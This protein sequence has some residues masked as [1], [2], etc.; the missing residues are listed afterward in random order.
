MT[1]ADE[2]D[3]TVEGQGELLTVKYLNTL[4]YKLVVST[5]EV[6]QVTFR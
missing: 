6:Q 5:G 3:I 2:A 4:E 1:P